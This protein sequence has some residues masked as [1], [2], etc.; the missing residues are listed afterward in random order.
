MTPQPRTWPVPTD[1]IAAHLIA[2]TDIA[3]RWAVPSPRPDEL[4]VVRAVGTADRSEWSEIV[5]MDFEVWHGRAGDSPRPAAALVQQLREWLIQAPAEVDEVV[6]VSCGS[7]QFFP[8]PESNAPR[9]LL[10]AD[11]RIKPTS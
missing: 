6:D 2:Q 5:V 8:D 10:T 11:V 4:I 1:L 3:V 7:A 9:F